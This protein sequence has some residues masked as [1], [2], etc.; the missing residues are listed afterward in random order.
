ML[1]IKL[2]DLKEIYKFD[3]TVFVVT[4]TSPKLRRFE[5]VGATNT[6]ETGSTWHPTFGVI[7]FAC[8]LCVKTFAS[9]LSE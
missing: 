8:A 6:F 2:L 3:N 4:L 1:R 7:S 5:I 9:V